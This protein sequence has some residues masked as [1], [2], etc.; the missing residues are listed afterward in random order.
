[1]NRL[2]RLSHSLLFRARRQPGPVLDGSAVPA[3]KGDGRT[4]TRN[5]AAWQAVAVFLGSQSGSRHQQP[6]KGR[7]Q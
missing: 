6:L 3:K 2:R 7:D 5:A 4:L 1:M